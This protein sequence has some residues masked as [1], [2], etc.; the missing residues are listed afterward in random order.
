MPPAP[1]CSETMEAPADDVL[2][3]TMRSIETLPA[4]ARAWIA[5]RSAVVTPPASARSAGPS[6]WGMPRAATTPRGAAE[7]GEAA[8]G[9]ADED[10]PSPRPAQRLSRRTR[11]ASQ[12]ARVAHGAAA[13]PAFATG[14]PA[15]VVRGN[16]PRSASPPAGAGAAGCGPRTATRTSSGAGLAI[17]AGAKKRVI[18]SVHDAR[19]MY[20]SNEG[21]LCWLVSGRR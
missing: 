13:A 20:A 10:R 16:A 6:R 5:A 11:S 1:L 2:F 17:I 19:E 14:S 18:A 4:G 21:G 3:V 7:G 8:V 9:D 15:R 12:P